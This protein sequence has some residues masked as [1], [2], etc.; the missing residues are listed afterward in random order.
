MD[1]KIFKEPEQS[2][3]IVKN[4]FE[5]GNHSITTL[6][7]GE[8]TPIFHQKIIPNTPFEEVRA[9]LYGRMLTL[10]NPIMDNFDL[11]VYHFFVPTRIVFPQ[12]DRFRAGLKKSKK[13][14]TE[15]DPLPPRS[16]IF[17][18]ALQSSYGYMQNALANTKFDPFIV[19]DYLGFFTN[20]LVDYYNLPS[21]NEVSFAIDPYNPPSGTTSIALHDFPIIEQENVNQESAYYETAINLE[22]GGTSQ[23][24][25]SYFAPHS[26]NQEYDPDKNFSPRRIAIE[27]FI[28]Y[29]LIWYDYFRNWRLEDY[30]YT[31]YD[32]ISQISEDSN[33]DYTNEFLT[34]FESPHDC[35]NFFKVRRRDFISDM[36]VS[37][38][39]R[40]QLGDPVNIPQ[41][42]NFVLEALQYSTQYDSSL[43]VGMSGQVEAERLPIQ[44]NMAGTPPTIDQLHEAEQ[45]Q[46]Y[47]QMLMVH[48][49][50]AR[51]I[52]KMLY[53]VTSSLPY[54]NPIYLG[55]EKLT[56]RFDEVIQTSSSTEEQPLGDFAGRGYVAGNS[57]IY[58]FKAD[59]FGYYH[60]IACIVP[61]SSYFQGL[62][63]EYTR[64]MDFIELPNPLFANLGFDNIKQEEINWLVPM[65]S[66]ITTSYAN[67]N[68]ARD[69]S[70]MTRY[71]DQRTHNNEVHGSFRS[72][73][74][75]WHV[76]RF[77]KPN[78]VINFNANFTNVDYKTFERIFAIQQYSYPNFLLEC[79]FTFNVVQPLSFY[80][81]PS[82]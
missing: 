72:T 1:T 60:C 46:K 25:K 57:S 15:Y 28:G 53:G 78:S 58:N 51:D 79:Q 75:N 41:F 40:P 68:N 29:T 54:D 48:G 63:R 31:P 42:S 45:S 62:P 30:K 61:H 80:C 23:L 3:P 71:I 38:Y 22:S 2:I 32:F 44:F 66:G 18:I 33:N 20:S 39:P 13:D 24:V 82:V 65:A 67:Q 6:R 81:N 37:G 64:Y 21:T 47:L 26:A 43:V 77:F 4:Y 55:G 76:A 12:F 69:F 59:E 27:P 70:Y 7:A 50:Q 36:F 52:D 49:I 16:S 11:F 9:N 10:L 35:L 34:L 19:L 5:L 8:L 56:F 14:G 73:L 74:R 17:T